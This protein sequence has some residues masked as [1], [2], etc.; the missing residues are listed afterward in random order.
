MILA[1]DVAFA[2]GGSEAIVES[3][4]STMANQYMI[5]GQ[6]NQT[7]VNRTKVDW[8]LPPS[9]SAI[10]STIKKIACKHLETHSMPILAMSSSKTSGNIVLRRLKTNKGR[11]QIFD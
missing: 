2:K 3:L 5:G 8:N 9:V 10:P 11:C 4:Y 6:E 1:I 7:L